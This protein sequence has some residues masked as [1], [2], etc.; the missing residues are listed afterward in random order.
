MD[1]VCRYS[2]DEYPKYDNYNAIN[3]NRTQDIPC[4]YEGLMGVPITFLDKYNPAQF[5]IIW[6][7]SGNTRASAPQDV[8]QKIGYKVHSEDRGGCGVVNGKR[9]YSRIIIRNKFPQV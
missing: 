5:D 4:D 2:S 8:L 7:A 9:Q 6:Q 3:V 1:L